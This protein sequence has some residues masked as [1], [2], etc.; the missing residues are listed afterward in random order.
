HV[1]PVAGGSF[2]DSATQPAPVTAAGILQHQQ[3]QRSCSQPKPEH[4]GKQPGVQKEV[5]LLLR[6]RETNGDHGKNN[7]DNQRAG[8]QAVNKCR[9]RKIFGCNVSCH[10]TH[11]FTP[12]SDFAAGGRMEVSGMRISSSPGLLNFSRSPAATSD[13]AAFWLNCSARI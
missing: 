5:P 8:T 1:P 3:S 4:K 6:Q 10:F 2:P 13:S 11:C 12:P 7:A 9:W